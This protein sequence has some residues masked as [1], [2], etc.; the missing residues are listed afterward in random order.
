MDDVVED[1]KKDGRGGIRKG[2]GRK[3]KPDSEKNPRPTK[4]IRA[5]EDEYA[6]IKEFIKIVRNDFERAEDMIKNNLI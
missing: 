1:I 2:A 3:P 6:L 4:Q 5:Y